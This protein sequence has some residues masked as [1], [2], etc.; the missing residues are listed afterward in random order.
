[1]N[2]AS[3]GFTHLVV[4]PG[5]SSAAS[6][7]IFCV[8]GSGDVYMYCVLIDLTDLLPIDVELHGSHEFSIK[9]KPVNAHV[10]FCLELYD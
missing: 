2:A 9:I 4:M 10:A 1:M 5:R 3:S 8:Q 6:D 7:L